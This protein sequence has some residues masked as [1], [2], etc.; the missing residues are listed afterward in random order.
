MTSLDRILSLSS[1]HTYLL[2]QG[3]VSSA[4]LLAQADEAFLL[5]MLQNLARRDALVPPGQD[6]VSGWIRAAREKL[7]TEHGDDSYWS[8][9]VIEAISLDEVPE[10]LIEGKA[11]LPSG[12]N[13]VPDIV[14][15]PVSP[16]NR[17]APLITPAPSSSGGLAPQ[18][19]PTLRSEERRATPA[20]R[21]Q[22]AM[23][24]TELRSA[25]PAKTQRRFQ[26]FAE[27]QDG[28]RGIEPLARK[29]NPMA[30]AVEPEQRR[31][32]GTLS[33]FTRRGVVYTHPGL[34]VIGALVSLVWRLV[35][36]AA[37]IGLPF[38]LLSLPKETPPPINVVLP[39]LGGLVALGLLQAYFLNRVRCRICTCHFFYSRRCIKNSK[40]H[41]FPLIGYVAA[42]SLH[43]LAFQWFRC[44]YCGT[45]IRLT[46]EN[47]EG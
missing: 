33:P 46:G 2:Q 5:K 10:V 39:I 24:S 43:L 36:L 27:Y 35:A 16:Q 30:P 20:E 7:G 44:M 41:R 45:A 8:D 23:Q 34:A 4:E 47:K 9:G 40:A 18:M 22:Q 6:Q 13:R 21:A 14:G 25:A 31:A 1:E 11:A 19:P 3:G 37:V 26:S 32:D 38:Y 28:G 15:A 42:L 12:R 29:E 17:P